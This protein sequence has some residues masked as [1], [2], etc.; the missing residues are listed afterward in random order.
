M[1]RPAAGPRVDLVAVSPPRPLGQ[2]R[3]LDDVLGPAELSARMAEHERVWVVLVPTG[4][5][6]FLDT[7]SREPAASRLH[8]DPTVFE[9]N[10]GMQVVLLTRPDTEEARGPA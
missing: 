2:V 5:T 9:F 3:R 8:R 10:G 7:L 6:T 4:W 1:D